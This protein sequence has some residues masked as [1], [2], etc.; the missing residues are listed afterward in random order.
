MSWGFDIVGR[1]GIVWGV[2]GV[3]RMDGMDGRYIA[4]WD[5]GDVGW[6]FGGLSPL[7][8]FFVYPHKAGGYR[9]FSVGLLGGFLCVG[10]ME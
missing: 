3:W 4:R 5:R 9:M 10:L 8:F 2:F 7:P 6:R 1:S